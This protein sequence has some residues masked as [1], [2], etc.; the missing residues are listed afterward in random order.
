VAEGSGLLNRRTASSRTVSSNLIP[1]AKFIPLRGQID[2]CVAFATPIRLPATRPPT[3]A[4]YMKLVGY[5]YCQLQIALI[6]DCGG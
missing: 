1:S 4:S 5:M 2:I 6:A 3:I